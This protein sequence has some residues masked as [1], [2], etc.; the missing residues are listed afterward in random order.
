MR[1][2]STYCSL[3]DTIIDVLSATIRAVEGEPLT[4]TVTFIIG[5]LCWDTQKTISLFF[6]LLPLLGPEL[7]WIQPWI[8]PHT[9]TSTDQTIYKS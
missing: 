2:S 4:V 9:H 1:D 3:K 7:P 5:E 8:Q 6:P